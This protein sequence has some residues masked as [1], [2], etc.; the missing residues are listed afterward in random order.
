MNTPLFVAEVCSNHHADLDRCRMLIREAARIGCDAVK[1]QLFEI[2]RLFAPEALAHE[3]E[4]AARRAWELPRSFIPELAE[5][6]R[7]HRVRFGC[8]PFDLDAVAALE[9]HVSFF[10]I[11]SYELLWS[12]LLGACART[13]LPLVL[14]T[15]MATLDEIAGAVD[16]LRTAGCRDLTLLHCV[17]GYP[18]PVDQ[19]NLS[20]I[21]TLRRKFDCPVGWSDHSASQAVVT[22]AIHRWQAAMIEFHFDLE[23]DGAEFGAGH[24]WLPDRMSPVIRQ[25]RDGFTADGVPRKKVQP[26]EFDDR[27]WR[28]D[29]SDGLRPIRRIR[30]TLPPLHAPETPCTTPAH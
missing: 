15:G 7:I 30:P 24:C 3:P 9:P 12:D 19:S 17:S 26:A 29:P 23:G 18:S 13:G 22:R 10:K 14:A 28:A 4:L 25:T 11:A 16:T 2:D 21:E 8:T 6:C 20:V 1:F 5:E 27:D